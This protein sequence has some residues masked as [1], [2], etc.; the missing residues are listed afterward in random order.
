[1]LYTAMH[2][3]CAGLCVTICLRSL[4]ADAYGFHHASD[5]LCKQCT[6]QLHCLHAIQG[7]NGINLQCAVRSLKVALSMPPAAGCI[8]RCAQANSVLLLPLLLLHCR[9]VGVA[10]AEG[11]YL[12][13]KLDLL[14]AYCLVG[15]VSSAL[16]RLKA[17]VEAWLAPGKHSNAAGDEAAPS[18]SAS[19]A[20]GTAG[21]YAP[22]QQQVAAKPP[23]KV[24]TASWRN[25]SVTAGSNGADGGDADDDE[26]RPF[27]SAD[28]S[29]QY[30]RL[31]VRRS[32]RSQMPGPRQ[33]L[34]K[35]FT[36]LTLLVR[37]ASLVI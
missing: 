36:K 16:A 21:L 6:A 1:M 7:L 23:S 34:A 12:D 15:P 24:S 11:L 9:G 3:G 28:L 29:H 20:A 37:G 2:L 25:M 13:K 10:T 17:A 14:L 18:P 27:A 8:P 19:K 5:L 30:A 35:L 4:V 31:V 33:V 22:V 32:L 26:L